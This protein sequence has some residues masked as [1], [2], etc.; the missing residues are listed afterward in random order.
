MI[1]DFQETITQNFRAMAFL[2]TGSNS[3]NSVSLMFVFCNIEGFVLYFG[4][5][6]FQKF[7][8][9]LFYR[10][11]CFPYE[12]QLRESRIYVLLRSMK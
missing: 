10:Q 7:F 6:I 12:K 8:F 11:V 9:H 2:T 1:F 5:V 3:N 4:S